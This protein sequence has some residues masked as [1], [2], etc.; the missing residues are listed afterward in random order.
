MP[1][2][3]QVISPDGSLVG[4]GA[5]I[6]EVVEL[7]RLAQPGRYRV[8]IVRSDADPALNSSRTWGEVIKTVRGRIKLNAPP[9]A[10]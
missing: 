8:E 10:D 6:D 7:V 3:Y 5:S 4:E 9:W 1:T 2:R